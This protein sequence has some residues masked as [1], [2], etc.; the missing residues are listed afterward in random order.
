MGARS[1]ARPDSHLGASRTPTK[2]PD[3]VDGKRTVGQIRDDVAA[4]YGLVPL[5]KVA[6]Y[7][8]VL[9]KIGVLVRR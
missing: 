3:L 4:I 6:E 1:S 2:A 8:G 9:E 5:E 7:L